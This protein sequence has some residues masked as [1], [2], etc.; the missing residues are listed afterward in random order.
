MC[1][2]TKPALLVSHRRFEAYQAN[3]RNHE[4]HEFLDVLPAPNQLENDLS[5]SERSL[6]PDSTNTSGY[7][8]RFGSGSSS[9]NESP[10]PPRHAENNQNPDEDGRNSRG[11]RRNYGSGRFNRAPVFRSLQ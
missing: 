5:D 7:A 9:S 4:P 3:L 2:A 1:Q 6:T 8:S 10:S 11:N